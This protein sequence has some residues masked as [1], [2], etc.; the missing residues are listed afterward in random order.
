MRDGFAKVKRLADG[1][2]SGQRYNGYMQALKGG[3]NV[4]SHNCKRET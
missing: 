2:Y 3:C 1:T 4:F